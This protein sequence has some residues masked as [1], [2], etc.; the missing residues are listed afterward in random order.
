MECIYGL[1]FVS[2]EHSFEVIDLVLDH[3]STKSS[4]SNGTLEVLVVE[5]F[6]YDPSPAFYEAVFSRNTEAA[7]FITVGFFGVGKNDWI[8]HEQR[9]EVD[10][11][12]FVFVV[13]V[14]G[15][16]SLVFSN[17]WCSQACSIIF[18]LEPVIHS[19]AY[20]SEPFPFFTR[21]IGRF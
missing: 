8:D 20:R 2:E 11:T 1:E 14:D 10:Q 5:V 16:E 7:F 15:Y 12:I 6:E 9:S 3:A 13:E 19:S 21:N 17:L 4:Q 18:G